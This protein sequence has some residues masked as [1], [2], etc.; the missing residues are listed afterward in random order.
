MRSGLVIAAVT[1]FGAPGAGSASPSGAKAATARGLALSAKLDYQGAIVQ[2]REAIAHSPSDVPAHYQLA[3]AASL[4]HD[5]ETAVLALAWLANRA[6]WDDQAQ[7]AT[8]AAASDPEL[9]W[10][11]DHSNHASEAKTWVGSQVAGAVDVLEGG[12]RGWFTGQG[13]SL[14]DSY[15]TVAVGV[16]ADAPGPHDHTC[17]TAGDSGR[18]LAIALDGF[19]HRSLTAVVS[20][21]D[22]VGVFDGRRLVV[23]SAPLGC[24]GTGASP[25]QVTALGAIAGA[26]R[27]VS[28]GVPPPVAALHFIVVQHRHGA[29][30]WWTRNVTLFALRD[31]Q[32]VRVFDATIERRDANGIGS[33]VQSPLGDLVYVAPTEPRKRVFRWDAAAFKFAPI[34]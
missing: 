18:V 14:Y 15:R 1:V 2:F 20:L 25:D 16:L 11:L 27:T 8:I 33:L 12:G 29:P 32:L 31:D 13:G 3:R 9:A 17:A 23:R 19:S 22:G 21:R 28:I 30:S 34:E 7:A 26:P 5:A 4:E 10:V 24:S 6:A